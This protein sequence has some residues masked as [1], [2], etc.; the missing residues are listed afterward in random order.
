[1]SPD[2]STSWKDTVLQSSGTGNLIPALGAS[3][4]MLPLGSSAASV[5]DGDAVGLAVAAVDPAVPAD[6]AGGR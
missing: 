6:P 4:H 5:G 3:I 1:M 2:S